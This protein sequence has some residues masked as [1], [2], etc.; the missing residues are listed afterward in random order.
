WNYRGVCLKELGRYEEARRSFDKAQ[1]IL[2]TDPRKL[3]R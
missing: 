3:T 2:R 1:T